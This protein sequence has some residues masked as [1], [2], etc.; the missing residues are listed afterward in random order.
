MIKTIEN[1]KIAYKDY[2]DIQGK[3]KREIKKGTYIPIVRGLYETN[4]N[5]PGYCLS[6][7]IYGPSYLSY[8]YALFYYGMIPERVTTYTLATY[9]KQKTKK[10]I[11]PFGTYIFSDVPKSAY[12]FDVIAV[13]ENNYVYHIATKEKALCD[14]LY[15]LK[16]LSGVKHLK[17]LLFDDLRI[18][19]DEFGSLDNKKLV[20]LASKYRSKN[21]MF[22]TKLIEE[23]ANA[24]YWPNA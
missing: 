3:I 13:E 21:L 11:T 2:Q 1:L 20:M 14:K 18:D 19:V 12:P 22:L 9:N 7:Y 17:A 4:V 6:A 23:K 10:Y 8:D 15:S 24:N 5:T 16:P